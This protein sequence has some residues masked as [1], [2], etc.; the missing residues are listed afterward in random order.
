MPGYRSLPDGIRGV[1]ADDVRSAELLQ[2]AGD[3]EGAVSRLESAL[4]ACCPDHAA[5]MPGWLCGRLAALYRS[6]KR[7]ADEVSL[8]ERYEATQLSEQARVRFRARLSKARSLAASKRKARN[9]ALD[10]VQGVLGRP[11]KLALAEAVDAPTDALST[12]DAQG[13]T[14]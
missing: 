7:Y 10:S 6:L 9:G 2:R 3:L 1:T 11:R 13:S 14:P 12:A 8:L 4:Q 5:P